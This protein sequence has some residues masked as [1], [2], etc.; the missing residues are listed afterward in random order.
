MCYRTLVITI[1]G[2]RGWTLRPPRS[3]RFHRPSWFLTHIVNCNVNLHPN[4]AFD[5]GRG[6]INSFYGGI[7]ENLLPILFF[8]YHMLKDLLPACPDRSSRVQRRIYF[9]YSSFIIICL[10]TFYRHVQ[11]ETRES[12]ML[13]ELT[14]GDRR[15]VHF[16]P[17]RLEG[18]VQCSDRA[19]VNQDWTCEQLFLTHPPRATEHKW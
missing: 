4:V 19:R 8:Y 10:K 1:G 16:P 7:R 11:T 15:S 6:N 5:L 9:L 3:L 17:V 2:G 18:K 13:S 14:R 12:N